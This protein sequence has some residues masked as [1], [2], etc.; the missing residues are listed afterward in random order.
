[1]SARLV[2]LE[3]FDRFRSVLR[4]APERVDEVVLASVGNLDERT[5]LEPVLRSIL[6]DVGD[7]PHGPAEIVDVLTHKLT[8]N[9]KSGIAA[10]ILK[11]KSFPKVRPQ[12][13]SHQIYRLEKVENLSYAV[14]V[15]SGVILDQAKEQFISTASRVCEAYCLVD[16]HDLGRLLIGFGFLCPRDGRRI[17]GGRCTCGYSPKKRILNV[18]QEETLRELVTAHRLGQSAGLVILPPA[19]GKT[20]IAALDARAIESDRVLYVAHTHE[21]LDVAEAEFGAVF[22]PGRV[23]RLEA[24]SQADSSSVHLATI[25]LLARHLDQVDP[26]AYDYL[27]VD[28]FHHAAARTYRHLLKRLVQ[29]GANSAFYWCPVTRAWPL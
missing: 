6:T 20:R 3:E 26:D 1:M 16:A 7:T 23:H 22:G 5:E 4:H 10:F 19:S 18:L 12:Q 11:G 25:Q 9:R 14:F 28:E 27:V 13:V 24:M 2:R 29:I 8:L 21:I 17:A 15:A